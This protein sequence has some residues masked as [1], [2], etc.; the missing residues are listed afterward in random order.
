M[1][2]I[3]WRVQ[4]ERKNQS[5]DN[6]TTNKPDTNVTLILKARG[7]INCGI[8]PQQTSQIC[9]YTSF[10]KRER[11]YDPF[12]VKE[13]IKVLWYCHLTLTVYNSKML[14]LK[15][16]LRGCLHKNGWGKFPTF[17]N[18]L[19]FS[20]ES[21]SLYPMYKYCIYSKQFNF[22]N[23]FETVFK[24]TLKLANLPWQTRKFCYKHPTLP[25]HSVFL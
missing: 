5:R 25:K 8:L 20:S 12:K 23:F 21:Q 15:G 10:F 1:W 16:F 14:L 9:M 2:A 13:I 19:H 24:V 18:W 4:S 7:N 17:T 11:Q 6:A 22:F 3:I